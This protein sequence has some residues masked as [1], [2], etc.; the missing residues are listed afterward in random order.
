MNYTHT[1][2]NIM[3]LGGGT[4][5]L[6]FPILKYRESLEKFR[7]EPIAHPVIIMIDNDDGARDLFAIVSK[8]T[9]IT[10]TFGTIN[11]FYFLGD[12]I[13]LSKDA[14]VR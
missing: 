7:H 1:V 11:P 13:Y 6:K 2:P 14:R 12:N 5:D 9:G 8:I 10:V 3:Q 4:G